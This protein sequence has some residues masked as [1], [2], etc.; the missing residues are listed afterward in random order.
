MDTN[1]PGTYTLTYTGKDL[2][3]NTSAA[4]TRTVQVV[5]TPAQVIQSLV[6]M[7][8]NLVVS[9]NL[10]SGTANELTTSL[11]KTIA[12]L[13]AGDTKTAGN[14]LKAFIN[15]VQAQSGKKL[16]TAEADQLAAEAR[17]VIA[18]LG[19]AKPLATAV[20]PTNFSLDQN[21]PNPFNPSTTLRYNLAETGQV[22][23]TVY[24]TMG[25]RVRVLV[26]QAQ[27]PGSYEVQWN[28][29][30]EAGQAVA[31]GIYL[32]VAG[33]RTAGHRQDV[34]P[35][36]AALGTNTAGAVP[37]GIAPFLLAG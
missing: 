37:T 14:Q 7:V 32:P 27:G 21:Y 31:G 36:V 13:N 2:S 18:G 9:S 3:G 26:D 28:G 6:K 34:V 30:D 19:L 10:P 20:E 22:Q 15:K 5:Q 24:N 8:D 12:W 4:L 33:R 23:L 35:Q 17:E 11:N 29:Q 1:I 16:T 25:Q